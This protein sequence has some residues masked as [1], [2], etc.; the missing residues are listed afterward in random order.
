MALQH[1]VSLWGDLQFPAEQEQ[2]GGPLPP[3]GLSWEILA[4]FGLAGKEEAMSP[5]GLQ[6][7]CRVDL[8]SSAEPWGCA[9]QVVHATQKT[10]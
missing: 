6:G 4:D 5:L 1:N 3:K 2:A 7:W 8:R 10:R 9:T